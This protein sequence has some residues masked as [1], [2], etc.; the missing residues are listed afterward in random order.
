MNIS[1]ELNKILQEYTNNVNE[2][3]S[4]TE[5]LKRVIKEVES[6]SIIVLGAGCLPLQELSKEEF[7]DQLK[8]QPMVLVEE[9]TTATNVEETFLDR[10][11]KE[12]DELMD[13]HS[14]LESFLANKGRAIEISGQQQFD[15][16]NEQEGYMRRYLE[17]LEERISLLLP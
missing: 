1:L 15:L 7:I 11:V 6:I 14:K 16:L 13:K 3:D 5:A 9:V 4:I 8:Q 2:E 17:I 10:L 12:K